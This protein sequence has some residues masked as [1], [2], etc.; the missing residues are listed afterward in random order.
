MFLLLTSVVSFSQNDSL[1]REE[2]KLQQQDIVIKSSTGVLCHVIGVLHLINGSKNDPSTY[3]S[4][5]LYNSVGLF[6]DVLAIIDL[7]Q[8]KQFKINNNLL[9]DSYR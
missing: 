6:F 9:K 1:L 4:F 5:L 7:I 2:L 3:N 8:Y